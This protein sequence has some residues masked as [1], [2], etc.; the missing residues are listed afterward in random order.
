MSQEPR[1]GLYWTVD[2]NF[3]API[4]GYKVMNVS[5]HNHLLH[6]YYNP[7]RYTI[8]NEP[9]MRE[10]LNFYVNDKYLLGNSDYS[11]PKQIK[12]K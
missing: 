8:M 9:L 11:L 2:Q 6:V 7:K 10:V 4:K 5:Y 3:P 12:K 1:T